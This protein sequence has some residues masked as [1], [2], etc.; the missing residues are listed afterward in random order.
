MRTWGKSRW[1]KLNLPADIMSLVNLELQISDSNV[2][3]LSFPP[4]P[5]SF[6]FFLLVCG[7]CACTVDSLLIMKLFTQ[8]SI[9]LRFDFVPFR[10]R[11]WR[12]CAVGKEEVEAGEGRGLAKY[13]Q[14]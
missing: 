12:E 8:H 9:S 4:S 10:I 11:G 2:R 14:K 13:P 7:V 1:G 3:F 6:P 5:P